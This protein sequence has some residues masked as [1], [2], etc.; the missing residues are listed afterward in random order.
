MRIA[1]KDNEYTTKEYLQPYDATSQTIQEYTQLQQL[2]VQKL[3]PSTKDV[4]VHL[5]QNDITTTV[6][7]I[8]EDIPALENITPL[9]EEK[10]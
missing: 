5:L 7:N 2:Q 9:F 4:G 1:S 10:V 3:T 8:L 6:A